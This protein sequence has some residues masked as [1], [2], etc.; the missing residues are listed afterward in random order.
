MSRRTLMW[1]FSPLCLLALAS[2]APAGDPKPGDIVKPG[3]P[4]L[5]ITKPQGLVEQ[6]LYEYVTGGHRTTGKR[7]RFR[8]PPV[9]VLPDATPGPRMRLSI[10]IS[11]TDGT[12]PDQQ[13][14]SVRIYSADV[15]GNIG[16]RNISE[17]NHAFGVFG[18]PVA[19]GLVLDPQS[20][21]VD[22]YSATEFSSSQ[23]SLL[24][25]ADMPADGPPAPD[26]FVVGYPKG[27]ESYEAVGGC[28][29]WSG[30]CA[31]QSSYR[32]WPIYI[33]FKKTDACGVIEIIRRVRVSLSRYLVDE[34][35]RGPAYADTRWTPV[36]DRW[37]D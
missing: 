36:T 35:P 31:L 30:N 4:R 10:K 18:F 3:R 5:S 7:I 34:T 1:A 13:D 20:C 25:A 24:V 2:Y 14:I 6:S 33:S 8:L 32:G 11:M 29:E 21:D 26:T 22:R 15:G 23:R 27:A 12:S 19:N 16:A 17:F 37:R 28:F 9:M